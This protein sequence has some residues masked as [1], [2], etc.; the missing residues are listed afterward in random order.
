MH[1]N[2]PPHI[3][4]E[5]CE[6]QHGFAFFYRK[7]IQSKPYKFKNQMI[8]SHIK[9]LVC[10]KMFLTKVVENHKVLPGEPA[11]RLCLLPHLCWPVLLVIWVHCC[12]N[13]SQPEQLIH[14]AASQAVP[15][16]PP[17]MSHWEASSTSALKTWDPGLD[18]ALVCW[19]FVLW[20]FGKLDARR[21][22]PF[23]ASLGCGLWWQRV[24]NT[25]FLQTLLGR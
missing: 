4:Q 6:K 12:P 22:L 24:S 20:P 25:D 15:F 14:F 21:L 18:M 11:R 3:C 2:P 13:C 1:P 5:E 17:R 9:F 23:L 10:S 16:A 8:H 19:P 7:S